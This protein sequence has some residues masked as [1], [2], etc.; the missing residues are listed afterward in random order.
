MHRGTRPLP[1]RRQAAGGDVCALG[2]LKACHFPP[3]LYFSGA[4]FDS[5]L[6]HVS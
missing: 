5:A 1:A 2:D 4:W 3:A 6:A